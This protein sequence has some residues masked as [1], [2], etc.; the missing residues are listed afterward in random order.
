MNGLVRGASVGLFTLAAQFS[1]VALASPT[2]IV[3]IDVESTES[4]PLPNQVDAICEDKVPCGLMHI[5]NMLKERG[6]AGT[7]FLNV[8]EY[9]AWGERDLR[10]IALKLQAA[11]QDVALHTHPQWAYDPAR[12]YMFSY[13]PEDQNR[14]IADG[15]RLLSGWTGLPVVAHRAGA[16]AANNDT[17]EA[18]QRNGIMLD[19][20]LFFGHSQSKLNGLR[21]PSN[22]PGKIGKVVELP[23][24]VYERRERPSVLWAIVPPFV[25][26]GKLDVNSIESEREAGLAMDAM[27]GADLPFMVVFLHSFSFIQSPRGGRSTLRADSLA[28]AVFSAMLDKIAKTKLHVVT[29][30][31]ISS[32]ADVTST[33][34]RDI[35]PAVE[36]SVPFHKYAVRMLRS[37]PAGKV[38]VIGAAVLAVG[39]GML[40][41]I[42]VIRRRVLRTTT[43]E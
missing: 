19:S 43:G 20:S 42:V 28:T 37:H 40:F 9:K 22:L 12:P 16:Y 36:I 25:A 33:G 23:I 3:T 7:F 26:I 35:V 11:G 17:I 2:V 21:L 1:D 29:A 10:N 6:F 5:A 38:L 18:L 30:R 32:I 8:Y 27:I 34:E 31:E 39:C 14:I 24:T 41:G 4:L 13:S 15:V